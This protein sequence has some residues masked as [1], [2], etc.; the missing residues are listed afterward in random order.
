LA[1]APSFGDWREHDEADLEAVRARLGAERMI[2]LG[3]S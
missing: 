2:L 3:P 1:P